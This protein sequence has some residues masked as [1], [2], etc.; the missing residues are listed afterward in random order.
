MV[1]ILAGLV[2]HLLFAIYCHENHG[3]PVSINCARELRITLQS[4]GF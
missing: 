2:T 1:P 3:E 4:D